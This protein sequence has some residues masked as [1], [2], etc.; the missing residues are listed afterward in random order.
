MNVTYVVDSGS[1]YDVATE[2]KIA[3][4]TKFTEALI[5][6]KAGLSFLSISVLIL[7]FMYWLSTKSSI[8]FGVIFEKFS[9]NDD[10]ALTRNLERKFGSNLSIV[11]SCLERSIDVLITDFAFDDVHKV[12]TM[13]IPAPNNINVGAETFSL[14]IS[15]VKLSAETPL[16]DHAKKDS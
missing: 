12:S 3:A 8:G 4:T 11:S 10:P 7:G 1:L 13:I 5:L 14:K 6:S 16:A 9:T 15:I 2:I